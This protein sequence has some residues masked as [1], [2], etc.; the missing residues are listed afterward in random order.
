MANTK[1]IQILSTS[2]AASASPD[3]NYTGFVVE[4]GSD[5]AWKGVVSLLHIES[6]TIIHLQSSNDNDE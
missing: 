6:T 4:N 1:N 2:S 5:V 3:K